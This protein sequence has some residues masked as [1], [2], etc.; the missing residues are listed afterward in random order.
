[1]EIK[2][3]PT[4]QRKT[5]QKKG[6]KSGAKKK[7]QN[8]V[9]IFFGIRTETFFFIFSNAVRSLRRNDCTIHRSKENLC[10]YLRPNDFVDFQSNH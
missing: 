8:V 10:F 9:Q 6:V 2:I 7:K 3:T 4:E 1:M 5:E